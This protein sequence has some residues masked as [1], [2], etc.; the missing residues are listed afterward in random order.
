M[1]KAE[2][3]RLMANIWLLL[4]SGFWLLNSHKIMKYLGV[5][6]CFFGSLNIIFNY[7]V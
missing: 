7:I 4:F 6:G 5:L 3:I 1:E 2:M